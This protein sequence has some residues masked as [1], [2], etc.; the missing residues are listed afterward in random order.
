MVESEDL[1]DKAFRAQSE[2]E[3]PETP[4]LSLRRE[5]VSELAAEYFGYDIHPP[6]VQLKEVSV[7]RGEYAESTVRW[8]FSNSAKD[9]RFLAVFDS[10]EISVRVEGRDSAIQTAESVSII[11]SLSLEVRAAIGMQREMKEAFLAA[12]Y[13]PRAE[14]LLR[15]EQGSDSTILIERIG[16]EFRWKVAYK[17]PSN[18]ELLFAI[19]AP[20]WSDYNALSAVTKHAR[21]LGL[22]ANTGGGNEVFIESSNHLPEMHHWVRGCSSL[23]ASFWRLV[24]YQIGLSNL[25]FA[26]IQSFAMAPPRI[27]AK[28]SASVGRGAT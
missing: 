28:P 23:R 15:S 8:V 27:S 10:V 5:E 3:L 26:T 20:N 11:E 14:R 21:A 2:D 22:H 6:N 4:S 24:L 12:L 9:L 7:G 25:P 17:R 16:S 1:L 13:I 18:R 19:S